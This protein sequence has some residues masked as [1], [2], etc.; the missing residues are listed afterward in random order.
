MYV[1]YHLIDIDDNDEMS[2]VKCKFQ[3]I[4]MFTWI[5]CTQ[6]C[7]DN[8]VKIQINKT[9]GYYRIGIHTNSTMFSHWKL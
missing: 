5:Q 1:Y 6:K 4:F 9:L 7:T 3:A 2:E 8:S